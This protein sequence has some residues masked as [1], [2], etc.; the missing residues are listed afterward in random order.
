[1]F[2]LEDDDE[3]TSKKQPSRG[4]EDQIEQ[5]ML[6]ERRI[7]FADPVDG[8]SAKDAIRRLWLMEIKDPGKPILLVISSPGG[9]VDAGLALWDQV[10]LVSS[11][12][13]TLVTGLAASM[14]SILSLCAAPGKRFATPQSRIMIHQ[15]AIHGVVRGQA[16]DLEIQA[17]EI[18]KTRKALVQIYVDSTGKSAEEIEKHLDRDTWMSAQEALEFGLLDGVVSSFADLEKEMKTAKK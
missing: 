12:V 7:F 15:P 2:V 16:T 5:A 18:L 3:E 9:S 10:K 13:V 17:Q 8:N 4:L 14:G 1:M 11:P 6:K